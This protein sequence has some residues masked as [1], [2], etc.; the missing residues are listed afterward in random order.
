MPRES[1][2]VEPGRRGVQKTTG[3]FDPFPKIIVSMAVGSVIL[4]YMRYV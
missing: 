3:E 2:E 1:S 4:W